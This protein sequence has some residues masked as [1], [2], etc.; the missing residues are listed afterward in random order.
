MVV[1][2]QLVTRQPPRR[3]HLQTVAEQGRR[4]HFDHQGPDEFVK[5]VGQD[6]ELVF[7]PHRIEKRAGAGQ[8]LDAVDDRPQ[9]LDADAVPVEDV[10]PVAHQHVVIRLVP[11]R[12]PE[13]VDPGA[14]RQLDPDFGRDHAFHVE[15]YDFHCFCPLVSRRRGIAGRR[16]SGKRE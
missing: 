13:I 5:R 4:A 1:H 15:T 12:A 8:R 14:F 3:V 16:F 11:R 6:H 10:E 9:R 7:R 2:A